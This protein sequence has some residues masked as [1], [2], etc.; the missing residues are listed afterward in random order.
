LFF[1]IQ[2]SYQL[3][4]FTT[5]VLMVFML[6]RQLSLVQWFALFLLFIGISLVQVENMTSTTPKQDVNAVYGLIAVIVACKF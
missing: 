5:A 3:K 2:V 1:F 6:R 4:I